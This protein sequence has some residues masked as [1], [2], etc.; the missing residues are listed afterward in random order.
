VESTGRVASDL[1]YNVVWVTDAMTDRDEESH[2]HC[3]EKLFP[4]LGE[5]ET[6]EGVLAK[7]SS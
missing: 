5:T 6:T 7:L 1:G 2:R 3:V 4:R